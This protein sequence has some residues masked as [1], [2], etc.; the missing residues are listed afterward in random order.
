MQNPRLQKNLILQ[1]FSFNAQLV[2]HAHAL[3]WHMRKHPDMPYPFKRF[4]SDSPTLSAQE[5]E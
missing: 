2:F 5:S 4:S 3:N 1:H